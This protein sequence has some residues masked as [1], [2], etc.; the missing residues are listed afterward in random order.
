MASAQKQEVAPRACRP[1]LGLLFVAGFTGLVY[2][3]V[4]IRILTLTFGGT[5]IA[6]S[7]VLC[8]LMG[9]LALGSWASGKWVDRHRSPLMLL[10]AVQL[11]LGVLGLALMPIFSGLTRFYVL[12]YQTLEPEFYALTVIR[13]VF[14]VLVLLLPA[15]LIAAVFPVITKAVMSTES[16][17]GRRVALVYGVDTMGAVTGA[18]L[19]GFLL[20]RVEGVSATVRLAA[21]L[22]LVVGLLAFLMHRRAEPAALETVRAAPQTA[23]TGVSIYPLPIGGTRALLAAFAVS[24]AAA[25]SYEVLITRVLMHLLGTNVYAVSTML[26]SFLF[27]IGAGSLLCMRLLR[28]SRPF[29]PWF[30]LTEAGIGLIGLSLPLQFALMPRLMEFLA[31]I[32]SQSQWLALMNPFAICFAVLL[33][34]T[35][36]MGATFPLL[37]PVLTPSLRH[38]GRS[39]GTLYAVNTLGAVAGVLVTTF[40]VLPL[41]GFKMGMLLAGCLNLLVAGVALY[42]SYDVGPRVRWGTGFVLVMLAALIIRPSAHSSLQPLLLVMPTV[43]GGPGELRFFREGANG[44]VAV[45]RR[46]DPRVGYWHAM[47]INGEEEGG[48]DLLSLRVFELLGNLP[49][50][51]HPD[52]ARPHRVLV[53]AF[54]MGITLGTVVDNGPASVS[55]VELVPEVLEASRFFAPYNHNALDS[56]KV[57]VHIEDARNFLLATKQKFD[58]VILDATH[59][60]SGDSWMLYTQECYRLA[61]RALA[62]GGIVA[63]WVPLHRLEF[64]NYLSILRTF[65][66]V[67]PHVTM[68][69]PLGRSHTILIATPEEIKI[70]VAYVRERMRVPAIRRNFELAEIPD[71][72][73]LLSYFIA[74][75]GRLAQIAFVAPINTDDLSPVQ[76]NYSRESRRSVNLGL[77]RLLTRIKENPLPYCIKLG[78]TPEEAAA[79]AER[80][81]QAH[82]ASIFLREGIALQQEGRRAEATRAFAQAYRINPHE[83]DAAVFLGLE[84]PKLRTRED[85][86]ADQDR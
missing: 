85:V 6:T 10:A 86:P 34:P 79:T 26:T 55:C 13:F 65:L 5:V 84:P 64:L 11:A 78:T 81:T 36:L 39:V 12:I 66:S 23:S 30:A 69:F 41:V 8:A 59:P 29:L 1:L 57:T 44:T 60:Q 67:F 43:S 52:H 56:S 73:A 75:E 58:L 7:A 51:L 22:N 82:E 50:F 68:W 31:R 38:L 45:F 27:G 21:G 53:L 42:Y 4:W 40:L 46:Q 17:F 20:L 25:L 48:S 76:F 16:G 19:V 74:A 35:L 80:I 9:G 83:R 70:D 24:G 54:G 32:L 3:V 37:A 49:F 62:P 61:K 72:Y 77:H 14:S 47:A 63:Q 2:E 28:R 71:E 15:A 18:A 33:L